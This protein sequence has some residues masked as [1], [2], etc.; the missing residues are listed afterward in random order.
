MK[1]A[2]RRF[3]HLAAGA[4]AFP[5][6][7]R[8]ARAQLAQPT[9]ANP[10]AGK[11]LRYMIGADWGY[12]IDSEA[13]TEVGYDAPKPATGWSI[14][15]CNLFDEGNTGRY[16]PYLHSSD[17]AKQYGEGQIDP[18]G[19]GWDKNLRE[20]FERRRRQGFRYVELDNPDA[21]D[22]RDV[23]RA[24]DLAFS[25]GFEVIAKNPLLMATDPH[26]YV[27][28]RAVVG[29][30]VEMDAGDPREMNELRKRAN[31][32][33]LPVWFVAY[34]A[35]EGRAWAINTAQQAAPHHN[36]GVTFSKGGEYTSS[37]DIRRPRV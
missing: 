7:S 9:E 2:R 10:L 5:A 31:K 32:P 13:V 11:P 35:S 21:Y 25:Y 20:Q 15:Y 17:T 6:V 23:L 26:T 12:A 14:G 19:P 8:I 33:E 16:G 34:G 18:S 24:I 37:K 28:H 1:L 36:M 27:A 4:V 3:L 22:V 29:V 30:I